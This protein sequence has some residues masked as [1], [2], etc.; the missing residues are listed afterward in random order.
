MCSAVESLP[1]FG[2][3]KV[4]SAAVLPL[5]ARDL[6]GSAAGKSDMTE[7]G[8]GFAN[9]SSTGLQKENRVDKSDDRRVMDVV[10]PG[11]NGVSPTETHDGR[12]A[13]L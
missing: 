10:P 3:R 9:S 6:V 11:T 4:D 13:N 8:S 2:G 12:L 7:A 5:L 1:A